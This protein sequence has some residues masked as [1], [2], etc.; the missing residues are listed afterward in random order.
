MSFATGSGSHFGPPIS[1]P[2]QNIPS[3]Q[4]I[5]VPEPYV[6]IGVVVVE[7][8]TLAGICENSLSTR[9]ISSPVAFEQDAP[10]ARG[11]CYSIFVCEAARRGF[12]AAHHDSVL[13]ACCWQGPA[14]LSPEC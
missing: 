2:L 8:K 6:L 5:A 14:F 11:A 7:N 10:S 12:G 9:P 1:G 4:I 13:V 3:K